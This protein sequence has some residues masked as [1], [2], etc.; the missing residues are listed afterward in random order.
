MGKRDGTID[1]RLANPE[2][3]KM[4]IVP[5]KQAQ[6]EREQNIDRVQRSLAAYYPW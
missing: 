6:A 3:L 1:S 2:K 4:E 5:L